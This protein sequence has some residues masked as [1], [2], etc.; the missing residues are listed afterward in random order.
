VE[1]ALSG[2]SLDATSPD[3]MVRA[4]LVDEG[5]MSKALETDCA[6]E[7]RER[8]RRKPAQRDADVITGKIGG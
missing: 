5:K 4:P 2:M 7:A 3:A 6:R 8:E 1:L